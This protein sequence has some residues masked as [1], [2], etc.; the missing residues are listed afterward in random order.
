MFSCGFLSEIAAAIGE[1]CR[2]GFTADTRNVE[3]IKE[4]ELFMKISAS[5]PL[6]EILTLIQ[7]VTESFIQVR[8]FLF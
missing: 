1:G 2:A 5:L 7:K 4:V 6:K 8:C 3:N